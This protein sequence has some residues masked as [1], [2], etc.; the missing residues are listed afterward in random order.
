MFSQRLVVTYSVMAFLA[1]ATSAARAEDVATPPKLDLTR[2]N[3]QPVYPDGAVARQEQGNTVLAIAVEASGRVSK[4]AVDTSSGFED[5]DKTAVD[6]V[7]HL[8]FTAATDGHKDIAGVMKL[9][10]HFQL[11]ALPK[12]AIT[13]ADV[14]ALKD[15]GDMMV[16]KRPSPPLGS[17]VAPKPVCHTKREWDA[18]NGQS[19]DPGLQLPRPQLPT[20][21]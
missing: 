6:S 11:S 12:A 21:D 15:I 10:V 1:L 2:M 17:F 3:D 20:R 14:Y 9:T 7:R 13:E 4:V 19:R 18:A 5:L 8:R 16:C